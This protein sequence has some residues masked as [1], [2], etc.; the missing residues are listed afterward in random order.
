MKHPLEAL[1]SLI[2]EILEEEATVPGKPEYT[3]GNPHD[4]RAVSLMD[5]GGLGRP[6]KKK[7][8]ARR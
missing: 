4:K 8:R 6:K 1:R 7:R 3:T 2:R 5:K